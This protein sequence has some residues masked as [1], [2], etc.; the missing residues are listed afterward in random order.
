[1]DQV[2]TIAAIATPLGIGGIGVVRISGPAALS[3][4]QRV[5]VRPSGASCTALKSHRVYMGFGV[6]DRAGRG[7]KAFLCLMWGQPSSRRE[8]G[9]EV[10]CQGG[11]WPTRR[12]LGQILRH[13]ARV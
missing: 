1:M 11:V 12:C 8:E 6:I 5:F 13:G 9:A 10:S 3:M 7:A 4:A 2:D